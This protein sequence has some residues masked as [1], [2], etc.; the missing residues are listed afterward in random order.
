[1]WARFR[2]G[3][4]ANRQTGKAA[5]PARRQGRQGG[6]AGRSAGRQTGKAT[7]DIA[8]SRCLIHS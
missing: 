8:H 5:R 7:L 1:M 6:K 4:P 2:N 3:K